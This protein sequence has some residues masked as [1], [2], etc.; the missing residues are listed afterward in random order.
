[1]F[2]LLLLAALLV[3]LVLASDVVELGDSNLAATVA[4]NEFV[5]VE[6]YAPW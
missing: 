4:D 6:F 3:A 1:M 2:N 5:L